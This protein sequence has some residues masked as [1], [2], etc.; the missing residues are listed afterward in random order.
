MLLC[1]WL[2]RLVRQWEDLA[3]AAVVLQHLRQ[4]QQQVMLMRKQRL[5]LSS[6]S[7]SSI[8]RSGGASEIARWVQL[9]QS[10]MHL[11]VS[12]V[13]MKLACAADSATSDIPMYADRMTSSS[14]LG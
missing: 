1:L 14:R 5:H 7:S 9:E 11:H 2:L 12:G 8:L 10:Q 13:V 4:Q 6:S 3:A